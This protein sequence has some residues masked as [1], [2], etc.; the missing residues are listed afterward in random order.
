MGRS[1]VQG[2]PGLH[3]ELKTS[4]SYLRSYL[5]LPQLEK[6]KKREKERVD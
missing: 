2:H 1:D 6:Q 3:S 4:L 5:P